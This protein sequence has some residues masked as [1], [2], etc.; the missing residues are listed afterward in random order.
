MIYTTISGDTFDQIAKKELGSERY[1][2][3]LLDANP[4]HLHTVIFSA[5]QEL[6]IP[7]L[8]NED[9]SSSSLPPWKR[10]DN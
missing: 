1:T 10:G 8:N 4:E 3:E 9:D 2:G 6:T 7:E 5:G